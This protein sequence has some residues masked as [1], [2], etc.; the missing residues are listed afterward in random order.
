MIQE[1]ETVFGLVEM[2]AP[3]VQLIDRIVEH[4][5]GQLLVFG[6]RPA[7]LVMVGRLIGAERPKRAEAVACDRHLGAFAFRHLDAD[8]V[9][10]RTRVAPVADAAP[11][12]VVRTAGRC[13]CAAVAPDGRTYHDWNGSVIGFRC[14]MN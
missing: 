6:R 11:V 10:L 12:E 9:V 13:R 2:V 3:N 14:V 1:A 8:V 5:V 4:V 7:A